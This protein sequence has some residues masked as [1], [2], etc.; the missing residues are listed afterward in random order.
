MSKRIGLLQRSGNAR[1]QSIEQLQ[2]VQPH[3]STGLNTQRQSFGQK[4]GKDV[5]TSFGRLRTSVGSES[6]TL[7]LQAQSSSSSMISIRI[8]DQQ[9]CSAEYSDVSPKARILTSRGFR[10]R[11]ENQAQYQSLKKIGN[12]PINTLSHVRLSQPPLAKMNTFNQVRSS[13]PQSAKMSS[14]SQVRLS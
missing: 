7:A 9:I 1:Y 12:Q 10:R 2:Q 6:R 4:S 5:T 13:Q 3:G 8:P 11:P 14:F